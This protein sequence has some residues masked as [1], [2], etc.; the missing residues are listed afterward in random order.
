MRGFL[1]LI[2]VGFTGAV[3]QSAN[4][5]LELKR[6]SGLAIPVANINYTIEEFDQ[7]GNRLSLTSK[8]ANFSAGSASIPLGATKNPLR[9]TV[10][11]GS[12]TP[13]ALE[14]LDA[15]RPHK[16]AMIVN[17]TFTRQRMVTET[18]E[19]ERR[20]LGNG[21]LRF[22]LAGNASTVFDPRSNSLQVI[23]PVQ[24]A[25]TTYDLYRSEKGGKWAVGKNVHVKCVIVDGKPCWKTL[26]VPVWQTDITRRKWIFRGYMQQRHSSIVVEE[27]A[28]PITE[29]V[30]K[31][32]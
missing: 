3:A 6:L 30:T 4:L 13:I 27:I 15:N 9:V 32:D 28:T 19:S 11:I 7:N 10:T 16:V 21:S 24:S 17:R 1:V 20:V 12:Y 18:V 31:F 29:N 2:F 22:H 25:D 26:G 5:Q 8:R 14:P 23:R